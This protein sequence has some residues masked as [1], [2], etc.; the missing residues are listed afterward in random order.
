MAA[1]VVIG[2]AALLPMQAR[3]A[4]VFPFGIGGCLTVPWLSSGGQAIDEKGPVCH[5]V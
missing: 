4:M 2:A 1:G 3:G 5:L